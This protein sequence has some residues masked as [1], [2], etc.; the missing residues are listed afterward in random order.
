MSCV[1]I[2]SWIMH[3]P[4]YITFFPSSPEDNLT[5]MTSHDIYATQGITLQFFPRA[6]QLEAQYLA[7][8]NRFTM[9]SLKYFLVFRYAWN[10]DAN[11]DFPTVSHLGNVYQY[12]QIFPY[13]NIHR[14]VGKRILIRS[15]A[16]NP[17][18][19]NIHECTIISQHESRECLQ[20]WSWKE[21]RR[22]WVRANPIVTVIRIYF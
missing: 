8:L 2:K 1:Y 4:S 6:P 15:S 21:K 3:V 19:N 7:L 20:F 10:P 22:A 17:R 9:L 18:T 16:E 12:I 11:F 14:L 5:T 13:L